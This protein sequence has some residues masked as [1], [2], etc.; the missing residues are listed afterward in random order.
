MSELRV[1]P[2]EL[3]QLFRSRNGPVYQEINR[4]TNAVKRSAQA[5]G[6][7]PV[8]GGRLKESMA[9][10]IRT[11]GAGL[12]GVVGTNTSYAVYVHEG[13]RPH[14]IQAR[15][16]KTLQFKIGS[17]TFY[18]TAVNHPGTKGNPWLLRALEMN[19]LK[20]RRLSR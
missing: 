10:E 11:E 9:M 15:K 17:Q 1:D 3:Q 6:N 13:T 7:V 20:A 12:V 5:V 19:G 16:A 2:A 18:R 4:L 14:R 8:K